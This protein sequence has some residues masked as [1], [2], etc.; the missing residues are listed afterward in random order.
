MMI[1]VGHAPRADRRY[2]TRPGAYAVLPLNGGVLLTVQLGE[3][4]DIQL[5]GGGIDKGE[6]SIRALHREVMEETGW[7][8]AKP[9]KLGAFKR[10]VFMPE[11][12][13]WAEK[14]CHVFVARPVY[15]VAAPTEADHQSLWMSPERAAESLGNDGDRL[16]LARYFS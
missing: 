15:Q 10:F 2:V 6:S 5:P 9:R 8:I 16:F 14:I 1:R 13:I 4:A 11:Y 12:D 3:R 7:R